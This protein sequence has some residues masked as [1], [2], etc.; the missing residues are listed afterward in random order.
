[1]CILACG[2]KRFD[3][4][5]Q[6]LDSL[7]LAERELI[8]FDSVYGN[9]LQWK[10]TNEDSVTWAL[11]FDKPNRFAIKSFYPNLKSVVPGNINASGQWLET[12]D[13]LKLQFYFPPKD[14][15]IYFDSLNNESIRVVDEETIE[16]NKNAE[17]IRIVNTECK[18]VTQ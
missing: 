9:Y 5:E 16:I 18:K 10:G 14:W 7:D 1:M 12:E 15:S 13:K 11:Y 6:E 2:T 3:L 8:Q 17:S 4:N